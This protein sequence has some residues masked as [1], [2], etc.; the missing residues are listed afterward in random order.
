MLAGPSRSLVRLSTK[1]PL[2]CPACAPVRAYSTAS[3]WHKLASVLPG[4]ASTSKLEPAKG[5]TGQTG[6]LK[7]ERLPGLSADDLTGAA[8]LL[9]APPTPPTTSPR[10]R[11]EAHG[12]DESTLGESIDS[13][14]GS[15]RSL[16]A[17]RATLDGHLPK[18]SPP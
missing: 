4:A 14:N 1:A 17:P 11:L 2:A 9:S 15:A 10:A 8:E 3:F 13:S 7:A 18:W 12:E 6:R 5:G 16:L